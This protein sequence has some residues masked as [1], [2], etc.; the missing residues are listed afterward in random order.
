MDCLIAV[1]EPNN[2]SIEGWFVDVEGQI[3][4]LSAFNFP[5]LHFNL[6]IIGR[7]GK[8][9]KYFSLGDDHFINRP[10]HGFRRHLDK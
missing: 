9:T 8:R 10:C 3:Y 2:N 1:C 4:P 5:I 6:T 7:I